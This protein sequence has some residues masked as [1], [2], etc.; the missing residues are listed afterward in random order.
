MSKTDALL[1]FDPNYRP[2]A[3]AEHYLEWT[4][5]DITLLGTLTLSDMEIR[6][7]MTD[8]RAFMGVIEARMRSTLADL[9][10]LLIAPTFPVHDSPWEP[11]PARKAA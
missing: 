11:R 8:E 5:P 2:Y 3:A 6:T 9:A 4:L 1:R 7:G 10:A